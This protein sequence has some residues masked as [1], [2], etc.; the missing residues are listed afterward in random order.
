MLLKRQRDDQAEGSLTPSD[1]S[2]GVCRGGGCVLMLS[3]LSG[4]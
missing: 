4:L 3:E 2:A 1:G